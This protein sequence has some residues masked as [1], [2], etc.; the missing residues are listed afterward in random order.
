MREIMFLEIRDQKHL[1]VAEGS[2]DNKIFIKDIVEVIKAR[3]YKA[4]NIKIWFDNLQGFWRFN[5]DIKK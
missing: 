1:M 2:D 4:L 3:G 5:S